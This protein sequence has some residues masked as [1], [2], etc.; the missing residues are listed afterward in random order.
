MAE[1]TVADVEAAR[2]L[3]RDVAI[4]TP[5]EQ[6]RWLSALVGGPVWLKCENLQRCGSFKIRSAGGS[7]T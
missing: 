3:I 6:S 2:E 1:L 4:E 5:M 7:R